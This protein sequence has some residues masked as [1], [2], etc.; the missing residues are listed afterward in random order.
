MRAYTTCAR[1]IL[2]LALA[3]AAPAGAQETARGLK[4][5]FTGDVGVSEDSQDMLRLVLA[6]GA[7]ALIIQGDFDYD[8]D[9]AAWEAMLDDILGPN[10]PVISVVGN[11][12]ETEWYGSGG[13]QEL[14]ADR[15]MRTGVPWTGELGVQATVNFRG[16]FIVQSAVDIFDD[17]YD[18]EAFIR[19][20]LA[21]D[22]SIWSVGSWHKNMSAMQV[23]GK[24][25]STGWGVYEE[26]RRGGAIIATAHEHSY[27]RTHLLSSMEN[28][29]V[30]STTEP[31]VLMDDDAATGA[32]EGRSFAFVSGLG[33]KSIRDQE[34]D[35]DWWA[36]VWTSTQGA[37]AG[38]LFAEFH[39]DGDP[40]LAHFY[41]KDI[42]GNVP[43][44]FL[45]RSEV[46]LEGPAPTTTTT[47]VPTTTTTSTTSTTPSTTVPTT[48][49]TSTTVVPTTTS[50]S[51]TAVPTTTTTTAAPTTS[52]TVPVTTTTV[53]TTTTTAAPTTTTST[54]P[55]TAT[56]SS[57]TVVPTTTTTIPTPQPT[58]PPEPT[59]CNDGRDNDGDGHVDL[60]DKGCKSGADPSEMPGK[61]WK[62]L[63]RQMA[64]EEG[65]S[66]RTMRM[67]VKGTQAE[68]D[69][70]EQGMPQR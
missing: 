62:R 46:G 51:T 9:P 21:A 30:A 43:D 18:H 42:D 32:D 37:A 45:V 59:E 26:S 24:G 33:G 27:S 3:L 4:V 65:V 39:V 38:A 22:D 40:R 35:G 49:S 58:P 41:F 57:T 13:Y 2:A 53:A 23:G 64:N 60:L 50:T 34:Q 56:T 29:T 44:D 12:D 67:R 19:D 31:L 10:F 16:L 11:H 14:L 15:M 68:Q 54:T 20:S 7:E 55:P 36:A 25:D 63:L 66:V 17:G 69:L 5:A 48:T 8:D 70:I 61:S 28:Q 6:E 52:S 47:T 1:A